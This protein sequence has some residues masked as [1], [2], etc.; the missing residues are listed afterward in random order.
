MSLTARVLISG[1]ASIL[2]TVVALLLDVGKLS[3]P[4]PVLSLTFGSGFFVYGITFYA[5]FMS[6]SDAWTK[7]SAL[8]FLKSLTF[9]ATLFAIGFLGL[10]LQAQALN[11]PLAVNWFGA[12]WL[13]ILF[14][15]LWFT[16]TFKASAA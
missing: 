15:G 1:V 16:R 13:W 12:I 11:T 10:Y 3:L 7:D 14:S 2:L 6:T 4:M 8:K 9:G 5:A